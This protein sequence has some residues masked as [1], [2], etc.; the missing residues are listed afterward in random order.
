MGHLYLQ[1]G[2][3]NEQLLQQRAGWK[4]GLVS[5]ISILRTYST[6]AAMRMSAS[7]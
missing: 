6:S 5:D 7:D 1:F 2:G 3:N 4:F